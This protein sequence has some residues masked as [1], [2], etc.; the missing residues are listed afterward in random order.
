MLR[1][2]LGALV[3]LGFASAGNRRFRG[4]IQDRSRVPMF[5]LTERVALGNGGESYEAGEWELEEEEVG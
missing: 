2:L 5:L 4:G 3:W 1:R